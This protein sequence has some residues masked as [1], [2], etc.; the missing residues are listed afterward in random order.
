MDS[1]NNEQREIVGL[2][3]VPVT[4]PAR[5]ALLLGVGAAGAA[6]VLAACGGKSDT[7]TATDQATTGATGGATSGATGAATPVDLGKASDITVGSG[8]IFPEQLVVVTQPTAGVFKAF[9]AT[10]T[11]LHCTVTSIQNGQIV[12]PC[13]GSHYSIVDGSVQSGPA[14]SPLAA[15]AITVANGEITLG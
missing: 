7:S 9:T 8:R 4:G 10:C 6:A 15:K 14:P 2:A 5:R 13:H 11:H 12:C 3:K 1:E